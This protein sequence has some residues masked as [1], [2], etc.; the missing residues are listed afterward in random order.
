MKL[1]SI[2]TRYAL[3]GGASFSIDFIVT[4]A[5]FQFL[6]L[7]AANTLGFVIANAANFVLGH[8]WVF[9]RQWQRGQLITMYVS[10][11]GISVVGLILSNFI[12]WVLVIQ[13]GSALL[14]AKIAATAI[15]MGWNLLARLT[16]VYKK[17][18]RQD[19]A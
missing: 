19:A 3:V 16:W 4:W 10:V 14:I 8:Q 12:V 6:P 15:V 17:P 7:L 11:L 2:V 1:N 13:M 18:E 9:G 5:A